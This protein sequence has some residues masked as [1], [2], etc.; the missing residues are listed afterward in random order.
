M[1]IICLV[2]EEL[3]M[4]CLV[5]EELEMVF[6]EV[7]TRLLRAVACEAKLKAVMCSVAEKSAIM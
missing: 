1:F 2:A 4:V 3:C 6:C 5:S 7:E